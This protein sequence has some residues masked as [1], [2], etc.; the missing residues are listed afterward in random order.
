MCT[1]EVL[2]PL[3]KFASPPNESGNP[4][5]CTQLLQ[6]TG[7]VEV[8]LEVGFEPFAMGE[9][10]RDTLVVASPAGG[11][12]LVPL[13]GRCVPPKPQGPIDVS[14]VGCLCSGGW[15]VG[16]ECSQCWGLEG[17]WV[18]EQLR[19]TRSFSV[20]TQIHKG[21]SQCCSHCQT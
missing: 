11:E 9:A 1:K 12:Y 13:V 20:W 4:E 3:T 10:L 2:A 6:S 18:L 7:G 15:D 16:A 19:H 5:S 14:E 17:S 21:L 8:E